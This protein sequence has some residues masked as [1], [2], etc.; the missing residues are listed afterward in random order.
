MAGSC[1]LYLGAAQ[2]RGRAEGESGSVV[3]RFCQVG[4]VGT[5]TRPKLSMRMK[6]E[7]R[8]RDERN[9]GQRVDGGT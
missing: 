8:G 3:G 1:V 6:D 2:R 7:G 5:S 4:P 9:L